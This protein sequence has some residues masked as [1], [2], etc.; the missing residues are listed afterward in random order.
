MGGYFQNYLNG[1][2]LQISPYYFLDLLAIEYSN[3][4]WKLL[5]NIDWFLK[6]LS[7]FFLQKILNKI[8]YFYILFF[9]FYIF[10]PIYFSSY[11]LLPLRSITLFWYACYL[12][13][14]TKFHLII[15]FLI[16]CSHMIIIDDEARVVTIRLFWTSTNLDHV[17]RHFFL[18]NFVPHKKD[19]IT[20]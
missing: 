8:L 14:I 10:A 11:N 18:L 17:T 5:L 7:K 1:L 6:K 19:I 4:L 12:N 9:L 2:F 15:V 13:A 16:F 20:K 3:N